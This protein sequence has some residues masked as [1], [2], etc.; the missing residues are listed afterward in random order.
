M[1]FLSRATPSPL[2]PRRLRIPLA[3]AVASQ[4]YAIGLYGWA[5]RWSLGMADGAPGP[6]S[7]GP[8]LLRGLVVAIAPSQLLLR[9][10]PVGFDEPLA[11]AAMVAIIDVLAWTSAIFAAMRLA[12]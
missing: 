9:A 11:A 5:T 6:H 1:S 4:V 2:V 3:M 12:G 7:V 8:L 10:V